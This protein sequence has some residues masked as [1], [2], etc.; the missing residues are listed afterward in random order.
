MMRLDKLLAHAGYG[1]RK[2]VKQL[3]K[4]KRVRVNDS[5][6]VLDKTQVDEFHYVKQTPR[7]GQCQIRQPLS[8]R[9]GLYRCAFSDRYVPDRTIGS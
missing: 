1:T 9:D 8:D 7:G 2:E 5:D 6:M 4:E 3:I